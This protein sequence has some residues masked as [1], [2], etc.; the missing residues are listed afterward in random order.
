MKHS[1]SILRLMLL[2]AVWQTAMAQDSTST[3][4]RHHRTFKPAPGEFGVGIRAVGLKGLIW[5]N[6]FEGQTIQFR[7]VQSS[8]LVLRG[9]LTVDY[10]SDKNS[11][12]DVFTGGGYTY[13]ETNQREF[14]VSIAPGVEKHFSGTRRLDPYV[15]VAVPIIFVGRTHSTTISDF[16][17]PDGDY[18]K[19]KIERS[20]PGGFGFGLDGLVGVNYYVFNR[21]SLGIEY[22][23]GFSLVNS[24]G[25]EKTKTTV[26][27]RVNGGA[28]TTTTTETDGDETSDNTVFFGNKGV[29]GLN[30]IFYFG[31]KN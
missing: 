8:S 14:A 5:E 27:E 18:T 26:K 9:D 13:D 12:K 3:D 16:E 2:C 17:A 30:L 25:E 28:E 1:I 15:G 11:E 19:Q 20:T 24:S 7:K 6:N 22:K 23:L 29:I 4:S 10:R 21:L 31:A